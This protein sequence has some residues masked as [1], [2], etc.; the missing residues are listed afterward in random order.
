MLS[1]PGSL[2]PPAA[3]SGPPP[4]SLLLLGR[5][6]VSSRGRSL[7]RSLSSERR[8]L[9]PSPSSGR[10]RSL[11]RSLLSGLRS[12]SSGLRSRSSGLPSRSSRRRS[13]SSRR[14]SRSSGLRLLS[15]SRRSLSPLSSS[16]RSLSPLSSSRRRSPAPRRSS[17]LPLRSAPPTPRVSRLP[18]LSLSRGSGRLPPRPGGRCTGANP[19]GGV[20]GGGVRRLADDATKHKKPQRKKRSKA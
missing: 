4:A 5:R 1:L 12:R 15:S 13:L 2:R 8:S 17:T 19:R 3:R 6:A 7:S 11:S 14:R 16:R 10:R 9:S 20:S 18:S